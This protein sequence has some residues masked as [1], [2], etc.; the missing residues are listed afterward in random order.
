[1]KRKLLATILPLAALTLA[2]QNSTTTTNAPTPAAT[3]TAAQ[4]MLRFGVLSYRTAVEAMPEYATVQKDMAELEKKYEAEAKR[5]ETD[6]NNKYEDFLEGQK[7][8]PQTILLKR[9]TELQELMAK[10]IQFR[11]ESRAL[12]DEARK[13]AMAPL[14]Q[15]LNTMLKVVGE[16]E[17]FAFILNTDGDSCPYVNPAQGTDI[18]QL[19]VNALKN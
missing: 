8:F 14:Y 7:D 17:G 9:Q 2:A 19:V 1:M 16:K 3:L 15:K 10:N 12:L 5:S 18:T 4:P 6:F 11:K 13:D